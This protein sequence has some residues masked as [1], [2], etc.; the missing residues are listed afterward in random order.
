MWRAGSRS[1][2]A[3]A[4]ESASAM[5]AMAE[6][7]RAATRAPAA[8]ASTGPLYGM[9]SWARGRLAQ[10]QDQRHREQLCVRGL[11]AP[12]LLLKVSRQKQH[13]CTRF[14]YLL[15]R[16]Q[17]TRGLGS[18]PPAG[19]RTLLGKLHRGSR[20]CSAPGTAGPQPCMPSLPARS[21]VDIPARLPACSCQTLPVP[22]LTW[23]T[24][25]PLDTSFLKSFTPVSP[26]G[27]RCPGPQP[28]CLPS[29]SAAALRSLLSGQG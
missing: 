8:P 5:A 2:L 13:S 14:P 12:L 1:D 4:T 18:H 3:A 27:R 10:E 6:P 7:G 23:G 9:V 20:P 24:P 19:P 28:R 16:R 15:P 11:E 21:S 29:P 17:A 22:C 26:G 25:H